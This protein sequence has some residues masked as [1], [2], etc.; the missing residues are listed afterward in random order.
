MKLHPHNGKIKINVT[1]ET[2]Y[3]WIMLLDDTYQA[4]RD[5]DIYGAFGGAEIHLQGMFYTRKFD[6]GDVQYWVY[7]NHSHEG[8][9]HASEEESEEKTINVAEMVPIEIIFDEE[10]EIPKDGTWVDVTGIVGPDSTK[11]LSAIREAKMTLMDEAGQE[12]VE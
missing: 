10:V 8:H 1:D 9:K 5:A 4:A 7:R 11:N 3:D 6:S 12:Y 2:F